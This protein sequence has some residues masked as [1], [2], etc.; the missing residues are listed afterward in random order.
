[1]QHLALLVSSVWATSLPFCVGLEIT[2]F[3][4]SIK[5]QFVRELCTAATQQ[6]RPAHPLRRGWG[7]LGRSETD[8]GDHRVQQDKLAGGKAP[9]A[10]TVP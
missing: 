2:G 9:L 3:S 7:Q 8:E 1:M 10:T 4:P 6:P 5:M